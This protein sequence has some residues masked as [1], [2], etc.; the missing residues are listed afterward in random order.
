LHQLG[1]LTFNYLLRQTKS[2]KKETKI[3]AVPT[4]LIEGLIKDFN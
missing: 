2:Y 1:I 4:V 3:R